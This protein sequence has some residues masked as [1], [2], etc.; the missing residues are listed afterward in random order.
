MAGSAGNREEKKLGVK[1]PVA[2]CA[3]YPTLVEGLEDFIELLRQHAKD[4]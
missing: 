1:H 2:V 3:T 4:L